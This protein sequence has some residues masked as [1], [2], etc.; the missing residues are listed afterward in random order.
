[1]VRY[2]IKK[3]TRLDHHVP[4]NQE[5][6]LVTL[7][8]FSFSILQCMEQ[9]I[10][11]SISMEDKQSYLHLWRYIGWL[12]GI[13]DEYLNYLTSYDS[14]RIISESIFY[15]YYLPS[16]T[17]KHFVHHSMIALYTHTSIPLSLNFYIG[18]SQVLLGK[19]LSHALGIDQSI[20]DRLHVCTIYIWFKVCR[21]YVWLISLNIQIF[22]NWIIERNK[23]ILINLIKKKKLNNKL[24]TFSL[25]KN[26]NHTERKSLKD[27]PC[28]YY[29]KEH[30]E[31]IKTNDIDVFRLRK[32]ISWFFLL[33]ILFF[34]LCFLSLLLRK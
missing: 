15:H 7:L 30:G 6:S 4:I 8:G 18:L 24:K 10:G 3:Y 32:P 23:L 14:A 17:S 20:I 11:I 9:R 16:Q 5:D 19:Q 22:N 27:C 28:G 21:M 26:Y 29:Q 2:K 1:M 12:I 25:I 13:K 34:I 33:R 31:R